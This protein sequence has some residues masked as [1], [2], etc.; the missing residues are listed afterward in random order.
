[1]ESAKFQVSLKKLK[2]QKEKVGIDR[3]KIPEMIEA[4]IG[5]NTD[6]AIVALQEAG[7]TDDDITDIIYGEKKKGKPIPSKAQVIQDRAEI[8][9]NVRKIG[10]D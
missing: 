2:L 6:A 10:K 4:L 8:L 1:M 9:T 3:A 5:V 7:Y